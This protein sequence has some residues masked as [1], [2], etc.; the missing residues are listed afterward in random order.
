MLDASGKRQ[1][2]EDAP[3]GANVETGRPGKFIHRDGRW[4][5]RLKHNQL[6]GIGRQ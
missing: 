5:E 2:Y 4:A 1:L 6:S 3:Q